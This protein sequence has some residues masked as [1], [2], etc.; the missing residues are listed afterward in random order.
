M[1]LI[2]ADELKEYILRSVPNWSEDRE[3]VIDCI[4]NSPTI[5]E[6]KNGKW[7]RAVLASTSGYGT[8]VMYQCSNCEN[9]AISDYHYCP[10]CGAKMEEK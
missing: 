5:E 8:M 7:Y 2:D 6:R 9:M 4:A 1:R 3:I 10:N